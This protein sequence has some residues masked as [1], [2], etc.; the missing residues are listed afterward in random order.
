MQKNAEICGKLKRRCIKLQKNAENY[1]RTFLYNFVQNWLD[2]IIR[3]HCKLNN[4]QRVSECNSLHPITIL[5]LLNRFLWNLGGDLWDYPADWYIRMVHPHVR[6]E[7]SVITSSFNASHGSSPR[8]WGIHG[9]N[10]NFRLVWW[11]IPT[12]VGNTVDAETETRKNLVHPHV[13]GEY[14]NEIVIDKL[15]LGSSPR[16]W[17]IQI[18]KAV[19]RT[20]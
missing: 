12:C 15:Q 1:M 4:R 8:A 13:R 18:Y 2:S 6:G 11:F 3:N 5:L 9:K 17:G 14:T 19:F 10:W 20:A 7:Y 16:A